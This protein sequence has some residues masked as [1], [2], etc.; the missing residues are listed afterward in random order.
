MS[1]GCKR[2]LVA[3]RGEIARRVFTTAHDMGLSTVAVYAEGDAD[4]P[5]VAEADQAVALG[6]LTAAE[7]YLVQEKILDA[8][9]RTGADAVHPGYGFLSENS[10]FAQAVID[11]GLTWIGPGPAAI[12]AMGD[13]LAAKK[14]MI[15]AGVPTL[16]SVE[17]TPEVDLP[18]AAADIG[19]PVLV[20]AAAGG[21]G[22]GMRV[23]ERSEELDDAVAGAQREAEAS[24]GDATVF[25]EKYLTATRHVEIQVLGDQHGNV[26]HCF[27]RECS[28]Q[29]RHQKIIEE[30][31]SPGIDAA[32][33]TAMG[34][35]AVAAAKAIDYRSAGTVEFLVAGG[36]ADGGATDDGAGGAPQPFYFLEVNTRLQVEHPVTEEVTGLD[37]VREQILVADGELLA[38]TQADLDLEGAAIEVRLYAEDAEAGF[39]PAT[40]TLLAFDAADDPEVRLDS[41]VEAGSVVGVDFDPMLAK[42]IAYAPTRRE[43]ALRLA[44]ALERMT[45]AGVTTN[46]DFLVRTLRHDEFLAGN[47]TTDFIDRVDLGSAAIAPEERDRLL[48]VLVL[49]RQA[50]H[51][52]EAGALAFMPSG[53][54]NS[55]MPPETIEVAVRGEEVAIA[56]RSRPD[57]S[58]H[59]TVGDDLGEGGPP[60]EATLDGADDDG[61]DAVIDGVRARYRILVD[62]PRWHVQGPSDRLDATIKPRFPDPGAETV[63]GGQLA[64]MP[65]NIRLVSVEVGERVEA[66][67]A[68]VV[69]EAMKMEHTVVAP[70]DAVVAEVRCAVGDQVDNGAV[71]VVLELGEG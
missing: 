50:R 2:I 35:A 27:E 32:T 60:I 28:I 3:N 53:Y 26:V 9:R 54:R 12:A 57:G 71:L 66:G 14:L 63:V 41:G 24:F 11:A 52:A 19:Y 31:P 18:T 49:A 13:K 36:P 61:I 23:V 55:S 22:K 6:G 21:G 40:G 10:A 16:P 20:K 29:R 59:I 17:I 69:M 44:L 58:F 25:L 42:V 67:Q 70:E 5:F 4:A 8:A 37:L 65:G 47:T 48:A 30:S 7:S 56:Y 38:F 34:E 43:A 51:R 15:A 1:S 68:L 39:L 64:P 33:R 45:I 46:R 62:G